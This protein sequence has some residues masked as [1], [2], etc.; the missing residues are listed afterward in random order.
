[1]AS[2]NDLWCDEII[3]YIGFSPLADLEVFA[4]HLKLKGLIPDVLKTLS[5][6]DFPNQIVRLKV[7]IN[8]IIEESR[9]IITNHVIEVEIMTGTKYCLL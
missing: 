7:G 1:M 5:T 8:Y 4:S 3:N 2:I 6:S 9:L